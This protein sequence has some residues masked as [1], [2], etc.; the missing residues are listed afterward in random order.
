[1]RSRSFE[2][3]PW[4][5]SWA[6]GPSTSSSP[7]C[8]TSKTP[9]SLRTAR[10]SGMTP[11]YCTGISQPAKGT[12]RAPSA[13][14]RSWIG[15][16]RSVCTTR[17]MLPPRV[18]VARGLLAEEGGHFELFVRHL[19]A[20]A[21]ALAVL[22]RPRGRLFLR[23]CRAPAAPVRLRTEACCDHRDPDLVLERVVDH[24]TEDHVGVLIRCAGDD[25][26]RLVHLEQSHVGWT[27]DVQEDS[28][29]ALDGRL[30]QRRRDRGVRGLS[31]T[32]LP[33]RGADSHQ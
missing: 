33:R 12:R 28:R 9:A 10:C 4:R 13:T 7:M 17:R 24:R 14:C 22:R 31:R 2:R 23:H 6:F 20:L 1:M 26:G 32:V 8:E 15:V 30:E 16:R 25:L 19:E 11:S 29:R 21:F 18:L 3:T 27:A 5:N